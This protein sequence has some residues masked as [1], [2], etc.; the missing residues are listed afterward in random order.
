MKIVF[1]R[2][3]VAKILTDYIETLIDVKVTDVSK[4][5]DDM[6]FHCEKIDTQALHGSCVTCG[7]AIDP[8]PFIKATGLTD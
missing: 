6:T 5:L 3:E 1:S 8:L 2:D 7:R 4:Y